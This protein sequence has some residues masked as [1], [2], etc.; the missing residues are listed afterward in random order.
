VE[1]LGKQLFQVGTFPPHYQ[2][3]SHRSLEQF[4]G[5]LGLRPVAILDDLD[6]E[7]EELGRRMSGASA[8]M[9][10]LAP[11]GGQLLGSTARLFG[12]L[13][14]RIVIAQRTAG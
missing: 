5:Q 1:S 4:V 8:W 9:R 6:F 12:S 10:R 2:Y 14:S 11:L 13:D 7:P 3:F